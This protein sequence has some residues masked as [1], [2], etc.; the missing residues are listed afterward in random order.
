MSVMDWNLLAA[1]QSN[2]YLSFAGIVFWHDPL[3]M[4][5]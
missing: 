5:G 3:D 1:D 4:I 2:D